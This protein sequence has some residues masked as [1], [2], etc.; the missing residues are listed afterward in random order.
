VTTLRPLAPAVRT[1]LRVEGTVQGVGF[2]PHVYRLAQTLGLSG[3]VLND[4]SGVLIEV[5]GPPGAVREFESRL[6]REAPPLAVLERIVAD[7]VVTTGETGFRI[8]PSIGDARA[9]A[10]VAP[11]TATCPDCLAELGDPGDR[12]YR[13][14]FINCTNCGPR[15]SIVRGVPYDRPRTTMAGFRMCPACRAEYEDPADRRF[16]AQPNACPD[17]GP[18][19]SLVAASGEPV[20]EAG[21]ALTAAVDA[22]RAGAILAVK[23]IGGFHLA[24]L[25]SDERAVG[26]LRARKHREEK[27]FALMAA[28]APMAAALVQLTVREEAFLSGPERPIVIARRRPGA[29]VAAAVAPAS[30]DLGVMLPY[31]PVHHLVLGDLGEP[32]VLTSGN[33]SDEPIAYRDDDALERLAGIANLF[34]VH[35]RPIETRT[36]DS[37]LRAVD[38]RGA[39]LLIRRSRGYAPAPLHLPVAAA[40]PLLACGAELKSTFCVARGHRAWVSHHIGD[41]ENY[42]TLRSFGDGIEHFRRLFDV[43]PEIVAF[44]LHPDYLSTKYALDRPELE[45][46]AVQHHHAHLAACLAEHDAPGPAIGA[47]FDGTGYGTDG[48]VWGGE[49]LA[50]DLTGFERAGH[51]HP[52]RLPGGA[53]AIREPWRMAC[54]WLTAAQDPAVPPTIGGAVDR[55]WWD[56]VADLCRTGLA[57]PVTTS[58]GRLFDAVAALCGIQLTVS[59]EGQAAAELEAVCDPTETAAYGLGLARDDDGRLVLDARETVA[60]VARDCAAGVPVARV[61]ARFHNA[62][63]A[64]TTAACIRL[65]GERGLDTVVLSGGSFQNRVLLERVTR[66]LRHAGVRVLVPERLPP[67]DGGISFGQAAVAAATAAAAPTALG[68]RNAS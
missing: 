39:P 6:A 26:T 56:R 42:E 50:G 9:D 31:S 35:D 48:T 30:A 1:R 29:E 64:A 24:C 14:P 18:R 54:A 67:N 55:R 46:V 27:P 8:A 21:A 57:S 16:H 10:P 25:A 52:V 41:L 47:I 65:A 33:V 5:E 13:Y 62:V 43:D 34:L 7:A 4:S 19:L 12:R 60:A 15:F 37:V 40:R 36:D 49:L 20:A 59:Y 61:A 3:F 58:M 32:L 23:G 17:C 53:Q 66:D 45:P 38:R 63:A 51:L 68:R 11:D 2:R 22:L 28:D 44:D